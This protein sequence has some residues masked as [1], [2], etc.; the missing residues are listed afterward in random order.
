MMFAHLEQS[1]GRRSRLLRQLAFAYP[2]RGAKLERFLLWL[3]NCYERLHMRSQWQRVISGLRKYNYWRGV[4]S[5][6]EEQRALA[7]WLQEVPLP[8]AVAV[9]AL[10]LD[11]SALPPKD[12]L[13]AILERSA[14]QGVRLT[15]EGVEILA[16]PPHPGAEPLR[17]EHIRGA[18]SKLAQQQ[19][20]PALALHLARANKGSRLC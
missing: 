11:L 19:F 1:G 4:A 18:L 7:A 17:E 3:A 10:A 5:A 15:L 9:D 20:V 2:L 6:I 13:H 16:L 8:P 12:V 14:Y